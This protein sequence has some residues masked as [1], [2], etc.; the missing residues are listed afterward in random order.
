[1]NTIN[2]R[3]YNGLYIFVSRKQLESYALNAICECWSYDFADLLETISDE[4]LIQIIEREPCRN[5]E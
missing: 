3:Y 4:E 2:G 5:C 1:M